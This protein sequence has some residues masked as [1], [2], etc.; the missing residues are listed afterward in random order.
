MA[1]AITSPLFKEH[2]LHKQREIVLGEFDRNEA[3]AIFPFN[4]KM[5]R[6]VWGQW[7]ERKEQLG[8]RGVIKTATREK[9]MAIKSKYYIPNNSLL[10]ISGDVNTDDIR[11][12]A[13]QYFLKWKAG[14]DPFA[15]NPPQRVP[16]LKQSLFVLDTI[17][18]PRT[19]V[20]TEWHGPSIGLDDKG[21]YVADVFSY[22]I[23]QPEHQFTKALQESGLAQGVGFGYY[24]QRYVGP[25][26]A[27]IVTTPDRLDT[28]MKVFWA[29]VAKFADSNYY[30]EE[31]F[32]TA[33]NVLRTQTIFKGE[34]L[35]DFSHEIG[36]WWST[37]GLDYYEHYLDDLS[38]IT[39]ADI[40][41]YVKRYI[42]NK[43]Y[44]LGVAISKAGAIVAEPSL[45]RLGNP[46][47]NHLP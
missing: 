46:A 45:S 29:Q 28:V 44:V 38:K 30:S 20:R 23:T 13:P 41:E 19:I 12:L 11:T 1:T 37:A 43:P 15:V 10:I 25:I 33:K 24:T 8:Q 17:E 35:S 18:E 27:Q 4:R 6:A 16:P 7:V 40:A 22:I 21:T 42:Q 34:K 5:D 32:E 26:T 36:F 14:P 2:E 39:R 31:E 47:M 9:M 3:Q